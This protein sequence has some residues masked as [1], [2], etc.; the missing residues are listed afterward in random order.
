V[1]TNHPAP[2]RA[3]RITPLRFIV[4]F[5]V[6]SALADM[7]YEGATTAEHAA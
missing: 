1:N 2:P 6:V 7:V 4:G 5:G 3:H